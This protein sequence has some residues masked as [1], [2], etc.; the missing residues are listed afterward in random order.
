MSVLSTEPVAMC[1]AW[2]W[3]RLSLMIF[4]LLV[5]RNQIESVQKRACLV[6]SIKVSS[7]VSLS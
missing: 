1:R 5:E 7:L 6:M 4:A 3:I 2:F